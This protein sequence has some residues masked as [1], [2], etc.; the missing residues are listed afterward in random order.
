MAPFK[1]GKIK[2]HLT[3]NGPPAAAP[4]PP[5]SANSS[6]QTPSSFHSSNSNYGEHTPMYQNQ[7]SFPSHSQ[8]NTPATS[9]EQKNNSAKFSD[10]SFSS[11]SSS[12]KPTAGAYKQQT[13][14]APS[15]K[16]PAGDAARSP[17]SLMNKQNKYGPVHSSHES[18]FAHS[19]REER[20][21]SGPT[22]VANNSP[23]LNS[24]NPFA[25]GMQRKTSNEP[26]TPRSQQRVPSVNRSPSPWNRIKLLNS[27]FPRYRH[28][29]SLHATHDKNEIYVI[30]GLHE[31][32]VYG[33]TWVLKYAK[34]SELSFQES[35]KLVFQSRTVD[36]SD[37]TP[38]PRVGHASTLCGN[39]FVVFGG[40]THKMNKNGLMDDDVY[41]LNINSMKWTVPQQAGPRPLGRY[42]HKI[43]VIQ[44]LS[45][46]S[47]VTT[48]KL[49]VFGG[50]FDDT[51][52]ND[53]CCYDL[54]SFRKPNSHWVFLKPETFIPPPITNHSMCVYE[55]KLWVFGGDT[56]QGLLNQVFVYD[57]FKNDWTVVQTQPAH[58]Q[59]DAEMPPPMQEHACSVYKDLMCVFGG[60]DENDIYLNDLWILNMK[61]LEWWKFPNLQGKDQF[62]PSA[63]SGHSL[64]LLPKENLLL[65]MGG[66]KMD[67][68]ASADPR[69]F[70][71]NEEQD[72]GFGSILYTFDLS[73]LG[74]YC[75]GIFDVVTNSTS[76]LNSL[77]S[78]TL[79]DKHL[80]AGQSEQ[81]E[82]VDET[83][84]NA[85]HNSVST[86]DGAE[87]FHTPNAYGFQ[88]TVDMNKTMKSQEPEDDFNEAPEVADST[89]TEGQSEIGD[90]RNDTVQSEISK[91][92]TGD[93]ELGTDPQRATEIAEKANQRGVSD[94][95]D[96]YTD[97]SASVMLRASYANSASTPLKGVAD[98]RTSSMLL[99]NMLS[100]N[101][102][103]LTQDAF[104]KTSGG[105]PNLHSSP[106]G[107][108]K[109]K[110]TF[111][112]EPPNI[113]DRP[114]SQARTDSLALDEDIQLQTANTIMKNNAGF[115]KSAVLVGLGNESSSTTVPERANDSQHTF[116]DA[117]IT[118]DKEN[119]QF[120]DS[121]LHDDEFSK[122]IDDSKVS[123]PF[124]ETGLDEP[125]VI[126]KSVATAKSSNDKQDPAFES[127]GM[128][129]ELA[130]EMMQIKLDT[131]EQARKASERIRELEA[132]NALLKGSTPQQHIKAMGNAD[133]SS[134]N[135]DDDYKQKYEDLSKNHDLLQK[136]LDSANMEISEIKSAYNEERKKLALLLRETATSL[137]NAL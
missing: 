29:A 135:A 121:V 56:A 136:E 3:S 13:S 79:L 132:E 97:E 19:P 36:I 1:F 20:N 73:S 77:S 51:Y 72:C 70:H 115:E 48:T 6:A 10:Q 118:D 88:K 95:F 119:M 86:T 109:R 11:L 107:D 76:E 96:T 33:D 18:G 101:A 50:Q 122:S 93:E 30:G 49:Y 105:E 41:L 66:D 117:D 27:P 112:L 91:K 39:A 67:Y 37:Q 128:L 61:T 60:K 65:V 62:M 31:Q 32:S 9:T 113:V 68:C 4:P 111:G 54:S 120:E 126:D 87:N 16:S 28:V 21:V 71:V 59:V 2:S 46:E 129:E 7:P 34:T 130:K 84:R 55:N 98:S 43:N 5:P 23:Q 58:K 103:I 52:F 24:H 53:L 22:S 12:P 104:V 83:P 114:T 26:V 38:P 78:T 69:N 64:T 15:S 25:S 74:K 82:A 8:F 106:V 90:V 99:N 42:G 40:D 124:R 35:G 45:S 102:N 14:L 44:S 125:V 85:S 80:G 123:K 110:D 92:D 133:I 81:K 89:M 134:S 100:S 127:V 63:R 94:F 47:N 57:P 108:L 131:M 137:E 17:I 116:E 75:P